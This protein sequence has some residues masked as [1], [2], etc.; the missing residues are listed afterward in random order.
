MAG[1]VYRTFDLTKARGKKIN[2]GGKVEEFTVYLV[3]RYSIN[4]AT[5]KLREGENDPTINIFD[6]ETITKGFK[7]RNEDF[8]KHATMTAPRL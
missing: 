1:Y 6:V 8:V 5:L 2:K 7:M 4:T 3:G